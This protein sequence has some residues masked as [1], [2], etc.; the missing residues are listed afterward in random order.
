[1]LSARAVIDMLTGAIDWVSYMRNQVEMIEQ[2]LQ[3][4]KIMMKCVTYLPKFYTM[5]LC[6]NMIVTDNR[7]SALMISIQ[8]IRNLNKIFRLNFWE[9]QIYSEYWSL[10]H[11]VS[12]VQPVLA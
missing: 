4:Y 6:E 8:D 12:P 7:T 5:C 10:G 11:F 9:K 2:Y 3:K 1:M